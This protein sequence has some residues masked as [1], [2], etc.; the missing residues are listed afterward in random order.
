MGRPGDGGPDDGSAAKVKAFLAE[1]DA[2][3]KAGAA[4]EYAMVLEF[5]QKQRPGL[6]AIDASSAMYWYEQYRRAAFDFDSQSVRPYFPYERVQ[7]GILDTAAK[8]FHVEFR[9]APVD[10]PDAAARWDNSVT[11]WDVYIVRRKLPAGAGSSRK[12]LAGSI[13]TC[14]RA[15]ARTNGSPRFHWCREL[16]ACRFRKRR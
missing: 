3:S 12:R 11:A 2:A 16:Q 7:Q 9:P 8:L 14:I 5:V 10:G 15:K 4:R 6:T 1:L 13:S